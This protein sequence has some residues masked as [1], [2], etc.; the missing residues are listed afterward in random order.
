MKMEDLLQRDP[1]GEKLIT[2]TGH[3]LNQTQIDKFLARMSKYGGAGKKYIFSFILS[4]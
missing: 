3:N 4:I 1:F 2:I